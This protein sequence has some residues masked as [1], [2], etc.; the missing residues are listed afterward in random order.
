MRDEKSKE[1]GWGQIGAGFTP[2]ARS[3]L[4]LRD[5]VCQHCR[6]EGVPEPVEAPQ[7]R[8][9]L[10]YSPASLCSSVQRCPP[11]FSPR[12][13]PLLISFPQDR[14]AFTP[15]LPASCR[16]HCFPPPL[17]V[18]PQD[19]HARKLK[20]PMAG[21]NYAPSLQ[22]AVRSREE[23][24][25]EGG[26]VENL[27]RVLFLGAKSNRRWCPPM[28]HPPM[29]GETPQRAS[30]R[31]PHPS[32]PREKEGLSGAPYLA[33][34]PRFYIL[35]LPFVKFQMESSD[36]SRGNQPNIGQRVESKR[37]SSLSLSLH[38]CLYIYIYIHIY[39]YMYISNG[40]GGG[41]NILKEMGVGR[42]RK[43][44]PLVSL[45]RGRWKRKAENN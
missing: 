5:F 7:I 43:G 15:H 45:Q 3:C 27:L 32:P 11:A 25:G 9:T 44:E 19:L 31:S 22:I 33:E 40:E 23:G 20:L 18:C 8:S 13:N 6:H 14:I 36:I 42:E 35:L 30:R 24:R 39:I 10:Q 4:S 2:G 1:P 17:D 38:S 29:D 34:L 37:Q 16:H 41:G 21:S 28:L 26:G 12:N